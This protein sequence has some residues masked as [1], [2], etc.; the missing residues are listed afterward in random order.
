M[1]ACLRSLTEQ[2][3]TEQEQRSGDAYARYPWAVH[4]AL[5]LSQPSCWPEVLHDLGV[6]RLFSHC[7]VLNLVVP[8]VAG[9]IRSMKCGDCV[10]WDAANQMLGLADTRLLLDRFIIGE[11]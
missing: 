2:Q 10:Y 11:G 9:V 6:S 7:L 8:S 3:C 1:G 5:S 4:G